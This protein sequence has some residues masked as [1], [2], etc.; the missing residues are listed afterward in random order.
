MGRTCTVCSHPE[1]AEIDRALLAGETK[2][3]IAA[4]YGLSATA[5]Q[6]HKAHVPPALAKAHEA[7]EVARADSLLGMVRSQYDR[8]LRHID[9]SE[10]VLKQAKRSKNRRHM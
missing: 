6:N 4:R 5:V 2:R 7:K 10:R 8:A 9:A 3:T 1:R